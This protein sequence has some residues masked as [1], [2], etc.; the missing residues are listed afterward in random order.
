MPQSYETRMVSMGE[1]GCIKLSAHNGMVGIGCTFNQAHMYGDTGTFDVYGPGDGVYLFR[2]GDSRL[3]GPRYFTNLRMPQGSYMDFFPEHLDMGS[4]YIAATGVP[5]IGAG[6]TSS[7]FDQS[8]GAEQSFEF[9][10]RTLTPT[11]EKNGLCALNQILLLTE[12]DM[13]FHLLWKVQTM[14]ILPT[15]LLISQE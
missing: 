2:M 14:I 4:N 12:L 9:R 1:Y 5:R 8:T 3:S 6:A 7:L 15:V 11:M 10:V 13:E